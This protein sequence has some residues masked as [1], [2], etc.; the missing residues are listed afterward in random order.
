MV[1]Y[2]ILIATAFIGYVL[3]WGQIRFWGATVITSLLSAIPYFGVELVNWVW[4]G[5]AVDRATLT[6]FFALHFLLPFVLRAITVLHIIFLHQTGRSNPLGGVRDM[7]KVP[8]HPYFTVKDLLGFR[9]V[10]VLLALFVFFNS[11]LLG[12]PENFIPAD[13]LST[14]LHIK[15]E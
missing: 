10:S 7:M 8:I 9:V 13:P 15:P 1:M 5:F 6:R 3:P 4:G 14:P 11:E 2:I 12:D